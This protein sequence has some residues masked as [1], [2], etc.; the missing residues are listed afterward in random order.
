M[1]PGQ[2]DNVAEA[3]LALARE[4]WVVTDRLAI[5]EAVLEEKGVVVADLIDSYQPDAALEAKLK[6]KRER[7]V[8]VIEDSLIGE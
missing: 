8:K 7:L 6:T 3:V 2:V 4:L 1:R 5:V